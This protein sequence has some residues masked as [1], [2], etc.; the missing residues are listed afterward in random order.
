MVEKHALLLVGDHLKVHC[1][2][3]VRHGAPQLGTSASQRPFLGYT[4]Q[5]QVRVIFG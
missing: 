3:V 5:Y 2:P 1:M 4:V